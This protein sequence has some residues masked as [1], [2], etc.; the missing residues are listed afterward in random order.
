MWL[1]KCLK[2]LVSENLLTVNMLNSLKTCTAAFPLNFSITLSKIDLENMRL[3]VSKIP[4]VFVNTTSLTFSS[5]MR[6]SQIEQV[7]RN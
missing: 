5:S 3:S 7:L 6:F 1:V 4:G 2:S